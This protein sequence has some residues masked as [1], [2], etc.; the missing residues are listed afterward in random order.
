MMR[1]FWDEWRG[2]RACSIHRAFPMLALALAAGLAA[3]GL[4][5]GVFFE[6]LAA[7]FVFGG[8]WSGTQRWNEVPSW[9]WIQIEGL[10]PGAYAAGKAVGFGFVVGF[11]LVF[12][13]P[14]WLLLTL[15]WGIPGSQT[16]ACVA[17]AVAGGFAAQALGQAATWS[18]SWQSR[19]FGGTLVFGWLAL[20][21]AVDN[22]RR[23]N[24]LDQISR[25]QQKAGGDAD[26]GALA[27]LAG[28][29]LLVWVAFAVVQ[30]RKPR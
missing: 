3:L 8:F 27:L 26:P 24:P 15:V 29:T 20:T 5:P 23:A 2:G 21:I 14:V 18:S 10:H 25:L 19:S 13:S 17:W 7:A 22:L 11:W 9:N 28:A 12:V 6:I 16:A 30:G 1:V 4:H